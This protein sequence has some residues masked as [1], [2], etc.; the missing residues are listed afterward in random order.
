MARIAI[1][2]TGQCNWQKDYPDPKKLGALIK[3]K[4]KFRKDDL[5][6][7]QGVPAECARDLVAAG[8]AELVDP[9]DMDV[10]FPKQKK[11]AKEQPAAESK[12]PEVPK[13]PAQP[14]K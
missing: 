13:K 2:I 11:E 14:K 3:K 8:K 5:D 1:K 10:L 12:G 9:A 7:E 6:E 4:L